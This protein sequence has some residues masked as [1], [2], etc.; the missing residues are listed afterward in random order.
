MGKHARFTIIA[1]TPSCVIIRDI[2][3]WDEFMTVTNDAESVVAQLAVLVHGRRLFYI[4]S[5]GDLDEL[6][7][8]DRR[9]A[10]FRGVQNARSV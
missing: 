9:F 4:D 5:E 7:I 6:L 10:G 2:G 3:P 1:E 8:D